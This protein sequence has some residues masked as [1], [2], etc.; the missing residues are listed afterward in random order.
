MNRLLV[1]IFFKQYMEIHQY[2]NL[3][4]SCVWQSAYIKP[5]Y[6]VPDGP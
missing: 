5:Q 2:N 4:A 1:G 6:N 3:L